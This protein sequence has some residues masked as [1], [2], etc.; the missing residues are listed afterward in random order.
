MVVKT[1]SSKPG[2]GTSPS[3]KNKESEVNFESRTAAKKRGRLQASILKTPQFCC[4]EVIGSVV[5]ALLV[6]RQVALADAPLSLPLGRIVQL[7]LLR[8]IQREVRQPDARG[9]LSL[10]RHR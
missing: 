5:Y 3:G 6:S 1:D 2:G 10:N 4:F 7:P 8:E 9:R